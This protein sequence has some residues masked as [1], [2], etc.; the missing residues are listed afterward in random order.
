M[1][2]FGHHLWVAWYKYFKDYFKN[3][4]CY[5]VLKGSKEQLE[6]ILKIIEKN[7]KE[8]EDD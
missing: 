2:E 5:P 4:D 6:Y 8:L 1:T 3:C 7:L